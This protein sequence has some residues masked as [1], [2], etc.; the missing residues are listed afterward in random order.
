MA[1]RTNLTGILGNWVSNL[2]GFDKSAPEWTT[3]FGNTVDFYNHDDI[4]K[5]VKHGYVTNPH[6]YAVINNI[7]TSGLQIPWFVYV[8]KDKAAYKK[9]ISHKNLGNFE[10][11]LKIEHKAVDIFDGENPMTRLLKK[12][13]SQQTWEEMIATMMGLRLLTGN[14]YG[15]G[16]KSSLRTSPGLLELIPL[17]SQYMKVIP[18]GSW[19]GN[20]ERYELYLNGN[21]GVKF[22]KNEIM[23]IKSFNPLITAQNNGKGLEYTLGLYGQ[24]PLTPLAKVI[25]QSNDGFTAQMKLLQNGHPLGILSNGSNEAMTE[26][27]QENAQKAFNSD[28]AGANNKG[29]IRLTTANLKWLAMGMNSVDLQLAEVQEM[30]LAT[31]CSIYG[32]PA[33]NVTGQNANFNTS[34]EGEKQKWNDAILPHFNVIR[35]HINSFYADRT[36]EKGDYFIDYDHRAVP[37]LQQDLDRYTKIVLSQMEHGLIN[38]L[39]ANRMLMNDVVPAE[40]HEKY[41]LTTNIRFTDEALPGMTGIQNGKQE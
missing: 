3:L 5:L 16:I 21:N 29:K 8:I 12:P 40:H 18:D 28:Y 24:S 37:S 15:Y 41:L 9:Y 38:G 17:P 22:N 36:G 33:P 31:V 1:R 26:R 11:M 14:I 30:A 4:Q 39:T 19:V 10:E 7:I 27:E 35:D 34:K 23:H 25:K 13:N 20:P 6:V 32:L 2:L